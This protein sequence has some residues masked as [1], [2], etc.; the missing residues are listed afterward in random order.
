MFKRNKIA[1]I[2]GGNIGGTMAHLITLK[3][4]GDIVILDKNADFARGKA[5]DLEQST[6]IGGHD[7]N[8]TGTSDYQ[9]LKDSDVVI[10]TA[11]IPRQPG[12]SRDDLLSTNYNVMK[13]VGEGVKKHCSNALVIIVTNPLDAMV[14]AF[15]KA[16]QMP[17]HKVIGMAGVL[18]SSRFRLFLARELNVSVEDIISFV[19]GG[20]GDGMVPLARYTTVSGI[21]ISE[22]IKM[23]WISKEKVDQIAER[24]KNGGGEIVKLLQRGSAYYAPATSA[25]AMAEAYLLNRRRILPCAAYLS[26]EYGVNGLYAGVP[27]VI[28]GNGVEKIVEISLDVEEKSKFDRSIDSVRKLAETIDSL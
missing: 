17:H 9:D 7:C 27:I 12:M 11:G 13:E 5:L 8:V 26:G 21:P 10:I 1:L 2:G 23:G 4:L 28:G 25:I 20:H 18:D 24:T 6:I 16:S 3:N 22:I 15:Q 14:Y 19:L